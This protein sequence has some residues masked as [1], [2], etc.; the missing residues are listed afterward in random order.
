MNLSLKL[1]LSSDPRLLCVTRSAVERL[2][3]VFG[4][5]EEECCAITLAVHEALANIIRHAYQGRHDGPVELT[6]RGLENGLE[7]TLV[8]RGQPLDP[9]RVCARPLDAV[10]VGGL[11]THIIRQVM[12]RVDYEQR[13]GANQV[14]LVKYLKG[15]R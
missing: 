7:F 10:E 15:T 2:A 13:P 6:C 3:A 1:V 14:R 5:A 4:F 11:G 12:D 9:A 8:D